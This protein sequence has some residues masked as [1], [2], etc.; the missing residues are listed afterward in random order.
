MAIQIRKY[1]SILKEKAV[2]LS[3]GKDTIKQVERDLKNNPFT[4]K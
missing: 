3:Y 4:A 1:E 2:Q